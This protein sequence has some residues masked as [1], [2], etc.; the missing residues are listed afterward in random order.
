MTKQQEEAVREAM[1]QRDA[2][3]AEARRLAPL[4]PGPLG[5]GL[6]ATPE[7]VVF[8]CQ[9]PYVDVRYYAPAGN[10]RVYGNEEGSERIIGLTDEI[11]SAL[12]RLADLSTIDA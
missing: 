2:L 7:Y 8:E 3:L 12:L 5:D 10:N 9:L 1:R 11:R 6:R 4:F